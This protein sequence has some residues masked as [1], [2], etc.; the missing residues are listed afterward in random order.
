[1]ALQA[2]C[3][4]FSSNDSDSEAEKVLPNIDEIKEALA[5]YMHIPNEH[6]LVDGWPVQLQ[7][8]AAP[9]GTCRKCGNEVDEGRLFCDECSDSIA[10]GTVDED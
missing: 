1:M 6:V 8:V 9:E 5:E 10:V 7:S 4:V 3:I 2:F